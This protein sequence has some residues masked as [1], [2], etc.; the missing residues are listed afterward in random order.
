MQVVCLD[1]EG[2]LIPEIWIAFAER[3][4]IA[5]FRRTT[6]EE[7]DYDKLMRWRLAL[8]KQ[9]GLKL[10]DIQAVIAGMAPMD[11]AKDFLD[12]LRSRFQ[13][14]ILSDTFYEFADPMMRQL[15]RPT[16]FCHKLVIDGD[17]FVADY[18]LRQPNQKFHAVNALKGLNYQVIAAGDSYNDTGMLG[19]ADAGFFIHPPES[20]VAQF[21]QFPVNRSYA[22]LKASIDG[23]AARLKAAAA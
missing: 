15:G 19:A 10:A 12:D 23:A 3:T 20:I 6:R 21:P 14:I 13:V 16:L 7:P 18:K 8:L 2:V 11:G 22:E 17:G 9:H 1:L 4:G 5:E